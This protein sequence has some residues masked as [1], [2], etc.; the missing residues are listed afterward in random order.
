MLV[1]ALAMGQEAI[2]TICEMQEAL[3]S[4]VLPSKREYAPQAV[5]AD[6]LAAVEA[7]IGDDL[8]SAL[9]EA[10][11]KADRDSRRAAVKASLLDS[12][13]EDADAEPT[14]RRSRRWRSGSSGAA[15]S[16]TG[17]RRWPRSR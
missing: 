9:R 7:R 13:E 1:E 3:A 10:E 15:S 6:V 4:E 8:V 17:A 14:K 11:D 16:M 2:T 5:D 12:L